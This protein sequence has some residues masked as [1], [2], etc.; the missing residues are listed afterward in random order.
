MEQSNR[1][2]KVSSLFMSGKTEGEYRKV[3]F[4][5]ELGLMSY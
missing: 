3:V 5:L 4:I 2:R 1:R